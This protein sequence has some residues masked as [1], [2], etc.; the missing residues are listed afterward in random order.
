[1]A[2]AAS[3]QAR[4]SSTTKSVRGIA[5][6]VRSFMKPV[7]V[8]ILGHIDPSGPEP[9]RETVKGRARRVQEVGCVVH[10]EIQR[11]GAELRYDNLVES[12]GVHLV[13][14]EIRA[15][16]LLQVPARQDGIECG[17]WGRAIVA[18]DQLMRVHHPGTQ[19]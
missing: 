18:P 4:M 14:A 7:Y 12:L 5:V 19:H 6:G 10:D 1:M 9:R 15:N 13:N 17:A 3:L 8:P 2:S 16:T 11:L